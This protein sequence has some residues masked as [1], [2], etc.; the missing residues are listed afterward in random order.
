MKATTDHYSIRAAKF[1]DAQ[2]VTDMVIAFDIAEYGVPD[3]MIEDVIELWSNDIPIETNTWII[4]SE[5]QI[6]AYGF[7]EE[8]SVGRIDCYGFVHPE[9]YGKG[10]GSLLLNCTEERANQ[11]ISTY[12]EDLQYEI[13][14]F[15]PAKSESAKSL[16][17]GRGYHLDRVYSRMVIDL[18]SSVEVP[19]LP[20]DVKLLPFNM[21]RDAKGLF[22]AYVESFKDTRSSYE[23]TFEE[24]I[25]K[26]QTDQHNQKLWT[27][28]YLNEELVGFTVCKDFPEGTYVELLGVKRAGRRKGIAMALLKTVFNESL[29]AGISTVLLSVDA[30]SITNAN[31]LYEK[32]GMRPMFQTACF[33]KTKNA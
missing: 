29:K 19:A 24:W 18:E 4:E 33:K 27:V 25:Q 14:V 11:Y 21:E 32:A 22:E 28:A 3:I 2:R 8:R 16:I 12:P 31:Q 17:T 20:A 7:L 10:I 1:E 23:T 5:N 26:K 15:A 9:W 30:N 6:V 13:N